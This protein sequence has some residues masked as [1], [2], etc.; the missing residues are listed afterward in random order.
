MGRNRGLRRSNETRTKHEDG[1][2]TEV[3]KIVF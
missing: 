3:K 2:A 1:S